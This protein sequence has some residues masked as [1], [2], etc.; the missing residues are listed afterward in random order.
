MKKLVISISL[1]VTVLSIV[2]I[3]QYN[4][5]AKTAEEAMS[6]AGAESIE[7]LYEKKTEDGSILLYQTIGT[8]SL[9][10]AYIDR[11]FSGYEFMD[12][13]ISYDISSLE[14]TAGISYV[15]LAQNENVPYTIY[16]GM[17]TN[18]DLHEVLVTEPTFSIAHSAKIIESNVEGTYIWIAYSPDFT[19]DIFS[20]IGLSETGD[21]IGDIEQDGTQVTIHTI[22]TVDAN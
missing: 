7:I 16:A 12:Y 18:E 14:E 3:F 4:T 2:Y 9:S 20:L 13:N 21:I 11:N 6:V 19:G 17:T 5:A 15:S 10:L 1:L 22:D 8:D